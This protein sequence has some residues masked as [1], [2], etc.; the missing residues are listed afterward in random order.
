M[1]NNH[2]WFDSR[3]YPLLRYFYLTLVSPEEPL[4]TSSERR[5]I[6]SRP[7]PTGTLALVRRHLHR[8]SYC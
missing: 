8:R 4:Y 2:Y 1:F 7:V 6:G 3:I 5:N